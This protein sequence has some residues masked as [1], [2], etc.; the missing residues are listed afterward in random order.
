M[1]RIAP[2]WL[3]EPKT[4]AVM[5]ALAPAR[6][7]FVGGCVRDALM[8]RDSEDIDIA[9]A[10]PPADTQNL[11][12]RAGLKAVP[13]GADHGVV[14]VIADGAPFEVATLRRDVATDGRRAVVAFTDQIGEDAARRDFTMNALYADSDG[15]V[16]D[17]LGEGLADLKARR[18]RFIGDAEQR[19]R[20]DYLRILRFF[21]F[22]AQFGITPLD[23]EG[24]AACHAQNDG[25]RVISA[26]RIGAEMKKLLTAPDP[27]P[28]LKGMGPILT[29]ILPAAEWPND[30][31]VAEAD[32]R[33]APNPMRRLAAL[34]AK[35]L[36]RLRLSKSETTQIDKTLA[37]V[38]LPVCEAAY[39]FG[40]EITVDA[41]VINGK[42]KAAHLDE[43]R[44]A[45][46]AV[47]PITAA[48]LIERGMA[49]GPHL[50]AALKR[51]EAVWIKS[52]FEADQK[53][54]LNDL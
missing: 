50:G 22:H 10:S 18:L 14:T 51:L 15:A 41:A 48:H 1:T 7:M 13:T 35:S 45:A 52:G 46:S 25:L 12:E 31:I 19:I 24:L 49:P 20:E 39:R 37:A 54:L 5:A 4:R 21:R 47:F 36:D 28:A 6:P 8:G 33:L 27:G 38:Q 26:E 43:I 32:W 44:N 34:G 40:M 2:R 42:A 29:D 11:A 53:E 16:L 17:P 30:L 3:T 9:V 23:A